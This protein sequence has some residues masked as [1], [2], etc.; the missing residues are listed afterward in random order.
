MELT[1]SRREAA[2]TA[3]AALRRLDSKVA[4]ESELAHITFPILKTTVDSKSAHDIVAVVRLKQR[5]IPCYVTV[6]RKEC[7]IA[8]PTLAKGQL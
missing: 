3:L 5:F 6:E 1:P 8:I 7:M 2:A 4:N